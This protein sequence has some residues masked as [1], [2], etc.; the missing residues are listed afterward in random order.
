[1]PQYHQN[2]ATPNSRKDLNN[3]TLLSNNQQAPNHP[4]S[5]TLK[6]NENNNQPKMASTPQNEKQFPIVNS[7]T[8]TKSRNHGSNS[9]RHHHL[10]RSADNYYYNNTNESSHERNGLTPTTRNSGNMGR[11]LF[12]MAGSNKY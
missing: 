7:Q 4:V 11:Q 9:S 8:I 3:E 10:T 12:E 2:E 1:M 5:G 6:N